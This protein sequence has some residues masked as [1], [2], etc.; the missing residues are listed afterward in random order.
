MYIV[1]IYTVYRSTI[2]V[3]LFFPRSSSCRRRRVRNSFGL[4]QEET[5]KYNKR[6]NNFNNQPSLKSKK[7]FLE[8]N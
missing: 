8:H 7:H 1:Y 3:L 5:E 2:R 6:N 4:T